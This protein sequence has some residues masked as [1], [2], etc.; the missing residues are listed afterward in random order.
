MATIKKR[1]NKNGENS[2]LIRAFVGKDFAGKNIERSMTWK[3]PPGMAES[4]ADKQAEKEAVLF[5]EKIKQGHITIDGKIKFADYA[6]KWLELSGVK[7]QT[8][9]L[10]RQRLEKVI[11]A[12]GHIPLE[13]LKSEHVQMFLK[14]LSA[15]DAADKY[16][17]TPIDTELIAATMEKN[18]LSQRAFAIQIGINGKSAW[19][20]LHGERV[21]AATAQKVASA[22]NLK[23][24][25]I[26]KLVEKNYKYSSAS[27]IDYYRCEFSI[28]FYHKPGVFTQNPVK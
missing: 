10:Y 14:N 20:L 4:K 18:N 12:I 17:Y 22:L 27:I 23:F 26:F 24:D 2:Y 8:K 3:P 15:I 5:E 1:Q 7:E 6:E 28:Y 16:L 9:R 11:A 19:R 21:T 25:K 13:K